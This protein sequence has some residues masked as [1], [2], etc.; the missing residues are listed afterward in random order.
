MTFNLASPYL[1]N[2]ASLSRFQKAGVGME[3]RYFFVFRKSHC[4]PPAEFTQ[5]RAPVV[6]NPTTAVFH[7]PV[8]VW[9]LFLYSSAVVHQRTQTS[10]SACDWTNY[11]MTG[12]L[13]HTWQWHIAH[14]KGSM[15]TA[16]VCMPGQDN[17]V[18]EWVSSLS[19]GWKDNGVGPS[20]LLYLHL[21][22]FTVCGFE[23]REKK[24]T[25]TKLIQGR[26]Y[27]IIIFEDLWIIF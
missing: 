21:W 6:S 16:G 15:P 20:C 9:T 25:A 18:T 1:E 10:R 23:G 14:T 13:S 2:W 24:T 5:T 17:I 11:Q 7:L 27:R 26:L 22:P 4:K 8:P 3:L 12:T 19:V